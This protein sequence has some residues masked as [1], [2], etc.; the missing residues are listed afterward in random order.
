MPEARPTEPVVSPPAQPANI[1]PLAMENRKAL[2]D[3]IVRDMRKDSVK[4]AALAELNKANAQKL[5]AKFFQHPA[6]LLVLGFALTGLVGLKLQ[7]GEWERQQQRLVEIH[8]VDLKYAIMDEVTKAVG[9]RNATALAIVE[10]LLGHVNGSR[11]RE[12]EIERFKEWQKAAYDWRV[13]SQVLKVKLRT[14][15]EGQAA[16]DA[17]QQFTDVI[18]QGQKINMNIIGIEDHLRAN[19]WVGDSKSDDLIDEIYTAIEE[20]DGHLKQ[21]NAVIV[22]ESR[23]SI[24]SGRP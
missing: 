3:D 23:K 13:N 8:E 17:N 15:L 12:E 1:D 9:A 14:Y 19:N 5:V 20:T 24:K 4:Q 11:L 18:A 10:P 6:T 21:L 16:A 22:N 2:V 7:Q